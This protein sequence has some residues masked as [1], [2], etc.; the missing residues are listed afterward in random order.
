MRERNKDRVSERQV[1]IEEE[2]GR[3]GNL[4]FHTLDLT[5]IPKRQQTYLLCNVGMQNFTPQQVR[6]SPRP[7]TREQ[8]TACAQTF[9]AKDS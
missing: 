3:E 8:Q 4:F 9:P 2:T 6:V 5:P 1:G 7:G